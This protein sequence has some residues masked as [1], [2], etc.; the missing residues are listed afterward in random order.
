MEGKNNPEILQFGFEGYVRQMPILLQDRLMYTL[1]NG[2]K[3][4]LEID[5]LTILM[6]KNLFN[7][8]VD[9]NFVL[10]CIKRECHSHIY[11]LFKDGK[12]LYICFDDQEK[13]DNFNYNNRNSLI[14]VDCD[15]NIN[16]FASNTNVRNNETSQNLAS[17]VTNLNKLELGDISVPSSQRKWYDFTPFTFSFYSV[18]N[19]ERK[20]LLSIKNLYKLKKIILGN[21]CTD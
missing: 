2:E 12:N 19:H 10:V 1:E 9:C 4:D 3:A 20:K 14:Y 13:F 17:D 15:G 7:Q 18:Q 11:G 8:C 6:L 16:S 5:K 21:T